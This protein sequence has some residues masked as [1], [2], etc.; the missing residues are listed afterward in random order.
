MEPT[1]HSTDFVIGSGF[2]GAARAFVAA[3]AA[4]WPGLFLDGEPVTEDWALSWDPAGDPDAP[5]AEILT[6]SSGPEMEDFWEEH[7]YALNAAGEGP[8][9]LF[10][11]LRRGPLGARLSEGADTDVA[12]QG[13][14]V[15]LSQFHLV[16]LVTPDDPETDPF[17]ASVLDDFL[18]CSTAMP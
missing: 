14:T 9:S 6:F 2:A 13:A 16:S 5:Y 4:R 11:R 1:G 10:H 18:R 17:S 15:L 3:Q 7:G 8:F 12:V